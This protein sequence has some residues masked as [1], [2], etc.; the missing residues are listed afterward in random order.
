MFNFPTPMYNPN[1]IEIQNVPSP[2]DAIAAALALLGKGKKSVREMRKSIMGLEEA[3]KSMP[4]AVYADFFKTTHHF[5]D[6]IYMRECL[7]PAGFVLTGKVHSTGHYNMLVQGKITV[8]TED[9][10]KTLSAPAVIKSKPGIKRVGYAHEDAIWITVHHNPSNERDI[11]KVEARLYA[12]TFEGAYLQTQKTFNDAIAFIGM[13]E[14]EVKSISENES[15]QIPFPLDFGVEV[16]PS[17]IHGT[18]M[19]AIKEF[20]KGE[21]IAPARISGMRTPAGRFTNHSG[22]PNA[23]SI[24]MISG[25]VYFLACEDIKA[26][27][28]ILNDYF[29]TFEESIGKLEVLKCLV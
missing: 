14:D 17:P 22:N 4:E 18:G 1:K 5:E 3:M 24:T 11:E 23:K 26:G 13:S 12:E 6:G 2:A 19:F 20:K 25:D 8:W 10:I 27:E 16:K 7:I 29:Y 21:T 28:E 9:G 15:D